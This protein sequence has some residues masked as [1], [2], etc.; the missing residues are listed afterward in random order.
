MPGQ[1][2]C[3]RPD[4]GPKKKPP[5]CKGGTDRRRW[6]GGID[7]TQLYY[8]YQ[9]PGVGFLARCPQSPRRRRPPPPFAQGG[10]G[11]P[12]CR[13]SLCPSKYNQQ[14]AR[15]VTRPLPG[16][17]LSHPEHPGHGRIK[18]GRVW[19]WRL[20]TSVT[21]A[22]TGPRSREWIMWGR[23]RP[24]SLPGSFSWRPAGPSP[25]PRPKAVWISPEPWPWS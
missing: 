19:P 13:S 6:S 3:G 21:L 2:K 16:D 9:L 24:F 8:R 14:P 12:R 25:A 17:G 7:S 11:W 15:T 18:P 10:A 23:F 5:L 1:R 22:D 4:T 20:A